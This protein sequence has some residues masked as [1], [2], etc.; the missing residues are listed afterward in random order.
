VTSLLRIALLAM[1]AGC[2]LSV[3]SVHAAD[4][5]DQTAVDLAPRLPDRVSSDWQQSDPVSYQLY[6]ESWPMMEAGRLNEA[7][8]LLEAARPKVPGDY[9]WMIDDGL[10]WSH[11]YGGDLNAAERSFEAVLSGHDGAYLSR[12]G[13][14]FVAVE[15]GRFDVALQH[16]RTSFRQNPYQLLT[17]YTLPARA[18][19]DAGD[20]ERADQL[21]VL[22]EWIYPLSSDIKYLRART[23]TALGRLDRAA[24][25][26]VDAA[27]LAPAYIDPVFDDLDL[28]PAKLRDGYHA[29]AWGLY[30]VGNSERALTRF[31][32]Y[33][34]AGGSDPNAHRGRG[35]ARYR[36]GNYEDAIPDLLQTAQL[37]PSQL[38]PITEAIPYEGSDKLWEITY[39]AQST[40]AWAYWQLGEFDRAEEQFR[41]VV[42]EHPEW[43]DGWNGLGW[44]LLSLG[45]RQEAVR[46]FR[47]A[48]ELSPGYPY[49]AEGL[50][51]ALEG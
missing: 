28:P 7:R 37:E 19:I 11:Y 25:K 50:F 23:L 20:A 47:K 44:T 16:L 30:F 26:A 34:A 41:R 18:M 35:F 22:G 33:I 43:I 27:G 4:P 31:E 8:Q 46:Q 17:S 5:D 15:R 49:A 36:L 14:G 51:S 29:L 10:A 39:D 38:L 12:K 1:A 21:L 3:P 24:R 13:L 42:A 6:S 48:L 2:W 32:Q 9:E 45:R 40:L